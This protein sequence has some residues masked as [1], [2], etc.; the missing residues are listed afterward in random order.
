MKYYKDPSL[1]FPGEWGHLDILPPIQV[2]RFET[3]CEK[4]LMFMVNQELLCTSSSLLNHMVL[5]ITL[6]HSTESSCHRF[7]LV[8]CIIDPFQ[9]KI[10][11]P[12]A[13]VL[14]KKLAPG[15]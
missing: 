8:W 3:H 4:E 15:D 12:C 1:L 6:P 11:L 7:G 10:S 9:L 2:L 5:C 14:T 13:K